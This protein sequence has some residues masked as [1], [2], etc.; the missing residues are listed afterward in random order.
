MTKKIVLIVLGALLVL[1]GLGATVPASLLTAATGGDGAIESGY[2]RLTTDT[3][4]LISTTEQVSSGASV[5][6]SGL[7][8]TTITINARSSG[9]P[10]FLGVARSS[11]V[12]AYLD[13]IAHEEVRDINLSPYRVRTTL[14][15]GLPVAE[16]PSD[17]TFW[18]AQASGDD[19]TIEWQVADGAYRFVMMNEDGS[20]GVDAQAQ[21]GIKVGGLRGLG[22][23][24]LIVGILIAL[25]GL[26]LLIWGIRT[27]GR[28]AQPAPATGYPTAG[29]TQP[30]GP[31]QPGTQQPG[32]PSYGPPPGEQPPY[33]QPP[34]GQPPHGQPPHGQPPY[35]QPPH[36]QPPAGPSG[37]E[38]PGSTGQE[39]PAPPET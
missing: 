27:R 23:G 37:Y 6:T 4:A 9:Q 32:P 19:S 12:D 39:P 30:Y 10:I 22:I 8:A 13:G 11:D 7:G 18:V 28:P 24:A 16:P 25:V 5:P 15:D 26:T 35:G 21:F 3:P 33:G 17:Q 1:C 38:R 2:H 31:P 34:Q 36:G 14:R 20:P 29:G